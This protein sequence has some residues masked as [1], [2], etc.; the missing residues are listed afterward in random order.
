[1]P[2]QVSRTFSWLVG[3]SF[4]ITEMRKQEMGFEGRA[5][6]DN[7]HHAREDAPI[8]AADGGWARHQAVALQAEPIGISTSTIDSRES[9]PH[10]SAPAAG[11]E[12][13]RF[14]GYHHRW[15]MEAVL[16]Y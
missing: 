9:Q 1:M 10:R 12:P 3:S 15:P 14:F 2:C 11:R 13:Y 8:G 6:I 7:A 16:G 5:A 4:T